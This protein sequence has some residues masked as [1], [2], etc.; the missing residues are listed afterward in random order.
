MEY[1][2]YYFLVVLIIAGPVF[3]SFLNC[4]AMRIARGEDFVHGRSGCR[5]C[6]HE[7][8]A[9]DLIPVLGY[10]FLKGRC[11]YC[12]AKIGIR[13]PVTE[14]LFTVLALAL[15]IVEGGP[16]WQL[17]R[18]LIF[19][20]CLFAAALTDI[21]GLIIPDGIILFGVLDFLVFAWPVSGDIV[22]IGIHILAAGGVFAFLLGVTL[23]VD[24][25]LGKESM[26]GG[27]LKLFALCGLF[28][29]P[30]GS[31]FIVLLTCVIGIILGLVLKIFDR[32]T[33][34]VYFPL[35]PAIAVSGY[36][37]LIVGDPLI[38]WY[39]NLVIG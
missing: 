21:D 25:I 7:L 29:G 30:V 37:M 16:S 8:S 39:L 33:N 17:L 34:G 3:G 14:V 12:G 4:M 19:T 22:R 24:R 20:G 28:A 18:D 27:D 38:S 36:V 35:G 23:I 15:Y 2:Y 11:R 1:L 5:S 32:L 6:G 26:G 13:Y 9:A 10:V 31:I